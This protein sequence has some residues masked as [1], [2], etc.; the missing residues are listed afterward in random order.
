MTEIRPKIKLI[1]T[2]LQ[3]SINNIDAGNSNLS[4]DEENELIE[5]LININRGIKRYSKRQ[6]CDDILHCSYSTFEKYL[7]LGL[8]P[9]GHKEKGFKEL[10]WSKKDF[11]DAV[12]A[13]I[14]KYRNKQGLF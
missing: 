3:E 5:S 7:E 1:K 10:S 12:I 14:N 4:E 2:L 11:N 13:R 8:I 9:P 6:I